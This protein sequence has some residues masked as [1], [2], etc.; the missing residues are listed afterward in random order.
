MSSMAV[1]LSGTF[2]RRPEQFSPAQAERGRTARAGLPCPTGVQPGCPFPPC[3]VRPGLSDCLLQSGVIANPLS[4]D[5]TVWVL[6]SSNVCER[7]Q[8]FC[9]ALVGYR[10]DS[11]G[12][13]RQTPSETSQVARSVQ[14]YAGK[15]A[16]QPGNDQPRREHPLPFCDIS[17]QPEPR[18]RCLTC[19]ASA[20]LLGSLD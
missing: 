7:L 18:G 1:T 8:S 9:R 15:P 3:T 14:P 11:A 12:P 17:E 10:A 5:R 13:S 20:G 4:P 2:R 19:E 16:H 6:I